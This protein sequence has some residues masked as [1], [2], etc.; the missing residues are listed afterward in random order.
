M[1]MGCLGASLQATCSQCMSALVS[2]LCDLQSHI[3][4]CWLDAGLDSGDRPMQL[5]DIAAALRKSE[6]VKD[7]LR[8]LRLLEGAL[9]AAPDELTHYAGELLDLLVFTSCDA[10]AWMC[11]L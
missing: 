9:L 10:C 3:A 11:T 4:N 2:I 5:R 7:K 6:E 1:A 8:A